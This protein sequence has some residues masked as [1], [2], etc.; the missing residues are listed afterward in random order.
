MNLTTA[1]QETQIA[2]LT[3]TRRQMRILVIDDDDYFRAREEA[4]LNRAGYLTRAAADGEE[5]LA[6][7][8]MEDFA[9]LLTDWHMPRLDGVGLVRALRSAGTRLPVILIS[10]S[11]AAGE[12]LPPDILVEI[13]LILPKD[14]EAGQ[15]LSAIS[16]ALSLSD[17][18]HG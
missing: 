3:E 8:R 2:T 13:A 11:P 16:Q 12:D 17:A 4:L 18:R 5:A 15:I 10:G 1:A 6:L 9:L 7:L 14:A